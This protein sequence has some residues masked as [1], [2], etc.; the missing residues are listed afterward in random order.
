MTW[1]KGI[2]LILNRMNEMM[3]RDLQLVI[4]GAAEIMFMNKVL[5]T[6]LKEIGAEI[7]C[8]LKI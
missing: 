7:I 1:Q 5:R 8:K 3:K 2:D 6:L 4:L